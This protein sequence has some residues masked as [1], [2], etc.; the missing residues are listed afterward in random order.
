MRTI[1]KI[2]TAVACT[3]ALGACTKRLDQT[4]TNDIIASAAYKNAAG[5]KQGL[6]KVNP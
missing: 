3:L 5:Y 1:H 6:A 2:F 4:P